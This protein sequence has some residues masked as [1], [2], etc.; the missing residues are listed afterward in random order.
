MA[1]NVELETILTKM[2]EV[3]EWG[4][5]NIYMMQAVYDDTRICETCD[6]PCKKRWFEK[7]KDSAVYWAYRVR[8]GRITPEEW[9]DKIAFARAEAEGSCPNL[10]H[11]MKYNKEEYDEYNEYCIMYGDPDEG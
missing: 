4:N 10:E 8:T 2:D 5:Q 3:W 7:T 6:R 11:M 1:L 9:L